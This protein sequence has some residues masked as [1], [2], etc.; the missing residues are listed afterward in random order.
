MSTKLN[1]SEI[2]KGHFRTLKSANG[3]TSFLDFLV[4]IAIPI[5][6]AIMSI[7]FKADLNA[8]LRS[9]LVNF[10]AIFTA[11]L[12]SVLVLVY[13]QE[14][15]YSST[16]SNDPLSGRKNILLR[17]LY[18]NISYSIVCS[19]G[20][21]IF[22]MSHTLLGT[23]T[24]KY[25]I[26]TFGVDTTLGV[27]ILTPLVIFFSVTIFLNVLMIVKRMHVLLTS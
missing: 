3:K 8:E 1:I 18:Y 23:T 16:K 12:L 4:F 13:D 6:L 11:L 9:L 24:I 14:N 2:I 25:S 19:I 20:L 17:E 10:G 15:K 27:S 26:L 22:S 5:L 21:V 7:I